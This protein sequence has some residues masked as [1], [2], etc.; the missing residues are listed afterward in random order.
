MI[1]RN[2]AGASGRSRSTGAGSFCKIAES[3]SG[4]SGP[5]KCAPP[6]RHLVENRTEGELIGAEVERGSPGLLGRHVARR[7][8][9]DAR[10]RFRHQPP[11]AARFPTRRAAAAPAGA[12]GTL[13]RPKSRILTKPARETITL[14]GFKSR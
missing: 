2:G 14:R 6:G 8:E 1:H 3:V 7:A 12:I 11:A 9:N 10:C 5:S 4:G 13:A